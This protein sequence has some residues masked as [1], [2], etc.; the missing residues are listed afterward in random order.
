MSSGKLKE[1]AGDTRE[2]LRKLDP[3]GWASNS[4]RQSFVTHH[5]NLKDIGKYTWRILASGNMP[6]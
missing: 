4:Y 6:V 3:F 2:D 5:G 1:L